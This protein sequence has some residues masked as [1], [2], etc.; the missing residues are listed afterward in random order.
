MAEVAPMPS[1]RESV[2]ITVTDGVRIRE[3]RRCLNFI[4]STTWFAGSKTAAIIQGVDFV[5]APEMKPVRKFHRC[6]R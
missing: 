4:A 6:A 5:D 3:R 1:A 2:A